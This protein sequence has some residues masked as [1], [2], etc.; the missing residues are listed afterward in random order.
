V[1]LSYPAHILNFFFDQLTT[2]ADIHPPVH[3]S[4]TP[5]RGQTPTPIP[6]CLTLVSKSPFYQ[7]QLAV[8]FH[9]YFF[10]GAPQPLVLGIG[11]ENKVPGAR[12][13]YSAALVHADTRPCRT[14]AQPRSRRAHLPFPMSTLMLK[15][16]IQPKWST[17]PGRKLLYPRFSLDVSAVR[18]RQASSCQSH[19]SRTWSSVFVSSRIR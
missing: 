17:S 2:T 8:S 14:E 15:R 1:L 16:T 3:R 19:S 10:C 13:S 7:A 12:F 9:L 4:P 5:T 11:W 18:V 6:T